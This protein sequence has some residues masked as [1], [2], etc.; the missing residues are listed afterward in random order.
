MVNLTI[1]GGSYKGLAFLGALEYLYKK[2]YLSVIDNF[3]GC[4][5]GGIIGVLF[6]IGYKPMELLNILINLNLDDFWDPSI[7]NIETKFSLL[8]S[9]FSDKLQDIFS[10]KE[11]NTKITIGE[12]NKKYNTNINIYSVNINT[13]KLTNLN[14]QNFENLEVLTAIKASYSI[15]VLF[16]PVIINNEYYVDGCLHCLNGDFHENKVDKSNINLGYIIRLNSDYIP[17]E[18]NNINE[19]IYTLFKCV[20]HSN[21]NKNI[22][23]TKNTIEIKIK[24]KY[25]NK[26]SFNDITYSDKIELF[27]EGLSQANKLFE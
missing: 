26:T 25:S 3:Y 12:F 21:T 5:V 24:E 11:I 9:K 20:M 10:V 8:S 27:Y 14:K 18:I 17:F 1:G 22:V 23:Y 15:P 4:S 6:I 19:Y 13:N 7:D 2:N 16:P